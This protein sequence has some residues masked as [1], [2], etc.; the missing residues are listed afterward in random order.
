MF[1]FCESLTYLD[2]KLFNTPD[3]KDMNSMFDGC[4]SL[5]R[6]D[7]LDKLSTEIVT[8]LSYMFRDCRSLESISFGDKFTIKEVKN[9][10]KCFRDVSY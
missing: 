8:D 1:Q 5:K 10:A 4:S 2:L 6:I 3:V 7:S 9:S